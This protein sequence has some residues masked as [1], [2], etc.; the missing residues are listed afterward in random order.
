MSTS[1][2]PWYSDPA[3]A[4][5]YEGYEPEPRLAA[6]DVADYFL[7]LGSDEYQDEN[8]S[9]LKLQK[10][11]YYAQGLCLAIHDRP[12]FDQDIVAWQHGPVIR[13]L[14]D[15]YRVSGSRGIEKPDDFDFSL[16]RPEDI[17]IM[18]DVFEEYGQFSAWKLRDMTH[19][20]GPW[21]DTEINDVI[22]LDKM[23]KYFRGLVY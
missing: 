21:K 3:E 14:W 12:L 11:C 13:E 19:A 18:D 2:D 15:T 22:S 8:I 16:V 20:E 5:L 9:N 4:M 7:V 1:G 10:L 17:D 23:K 6:Q